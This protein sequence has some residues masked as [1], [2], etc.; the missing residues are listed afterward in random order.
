MKRTAYI[1]AILVI[2]ALAVAGCTTACIPVNP[3]ATIHDQSGNCYV[4]IENVSYSTWG[5]DCT[6]IKIGETNW[7]TFATFISGS[8]INKICEGKP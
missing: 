7:V 6:K 8:P 3:T 1:L 4:I 5:F 2:A